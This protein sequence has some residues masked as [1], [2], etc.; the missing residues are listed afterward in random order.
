MNEEQ[1]REAL[2]TCL[3]AV[4]NGQETIESALAKFPGLADELRPE[5]EAALW[6][7]T[8]KQ[9]LDPR[10]GFVETSK[11]RLVAQVQ[12]ESRQQVP[13]KR[14]LFGWSRRLMRLAVAVVVIFAL[15]CSNIFIAAAAPGEWAYPLKIAVENVRL[16]LSFSDGTRVALHIQFAQ[17][18]LDEVA[19]LVDGQRFDELEA[20]LENYKSHI[21][22][23]NQIVTA[24]ADQGMPEAGMLATM[25]SNA[26]NRNIMELE[27]LLDK[28]PNGQREIFEDALSFSADEIASMQVDQPGHAYPAQTPTRRAGPTQTLSSDGPPTHQPTQTPRVEPTRRPTNTPRPQ[29]THKPT[30][31]GQPGNGDKGNSA[32]S[33]KGGSDKGNSSR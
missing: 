11:R 22:Q 4:L 16:A 10:P 9:T 32:N 30:D 6:L 26:L 17:N 31:A 1:I 29:P 14:R 27:R 18:R 23:A 2:Q 20:P 12:A 25:L 24:L 33:D 28:A 3:D 5:L 8:R 13:R 7:H 15:L 19:G 21:H